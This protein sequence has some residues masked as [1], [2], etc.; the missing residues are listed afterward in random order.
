MGDEKFW[1]FFLSSMMYVLDYQHKEGE[2]L[3]SYQISNLQGDVV[4]QNR[5]WVRMCMEQLRDYRRE[6]T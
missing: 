6:E 1:F 5:D 2:G 3:L 4:Q